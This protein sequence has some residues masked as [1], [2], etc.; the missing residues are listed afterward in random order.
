MILIPV[1]LLTIGSFAL[2]KSQTPMYRSTS[3]SYFSLGLGDSASD[4]FQGS[5]YTQQQLGSFARLATEP[6]VLNKVIEE[7]GLTESARS[8]SRRVSASASPETVIIDITVTDANAA[9]AA[10]I[11]NS[12][13]A[14]FTEAVRDLSPRMS[15][16]KPS[17]SAT[18]I[19]RALPASYA[20]SPNTRQSVAIGLIGGLLLGLLAAVAR[21]ALDT[22]VRAADD[23]P[24]G[25]GVLAEVED[26]ARLLRRR[27]MSRGLTKERAV[28][29]RTESYRK[30]RTNLR[31][32][33]VDNPVRVLVI[34]SSVAGEGK[35]TTAVELARVLAEG[36]E[37]VLLVDGDLRQPKVATYLGLEGSLGLADVLAGTT[38]LE[39][40]I[41]RWGGAGLSVLAS[42]SIPPN[43]SELLG[44]RAFGELVAKVRGEFDHVIIDSPP[45][46]PV[47]DASVTSV[48]VDGVLLVVRYGR[49]TQ[50]QV[51][52]AVESLNTV[53]AR[54]LGAVINATPGR[55]SWV[56]SSGYDYQSQPLVDA[57]PLERA[58]DGGA[59]RA[60]QLNGV[61]DVQRSES[62]A[63][64]L[65][66][67][68]AASKR[69]ERSGAADADTQRTTR[70]TRTRRSASKPA[71]PPSSPPTRNSMTGVTTTATETESEFQQKA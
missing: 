48:M 71:G 53:E 11:A 61:R 9:Q 43:P 29:I 5:N 51:N 66:A 32:L 68:P 18:T 21:E 23:L 22:R 40:V 45:L 37:R 10:A 36:G 24:E 30:L 4:I 33:D 63:A 56:A 39:S 58:V 34:T 60:R 69:P 2:A 13:T 55:R 67:G 7:L 6:V 8:L 64:S 50:R 52:T 25:V 70:R 26:D 59:G 38:D 3:S 65:T 46:L 57:Q 14:Q 1:L 12:V 49:T 16:G 31:F 41:Q 15:N 44:S 28:A 54:I 19:S 17:I 27:R 62:T 47:T 42:G 20:Y 35:S